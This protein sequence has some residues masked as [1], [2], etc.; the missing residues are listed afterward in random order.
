MVVTFPIQF[1][2]TVF[3]AYSCIEHDSRPSYANTVY[4]ITTSGM[5]VGSSST[6]MRHMWL[7]IGM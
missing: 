7:A 6:S 5:L 3:A 1:P 4:K 2:S